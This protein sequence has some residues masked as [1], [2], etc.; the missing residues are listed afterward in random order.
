MRNLKLL[1]PDNLQR[2]LN[3]NTQ[4]ALRNKNVEIVGV[5]DNGEQ[6]YEMIFELKPDIVI[7]DNQIHKL[8]GIEL[9]K[10]IENSDLAYI[11]KFI[12]ITDDTDKISDNKSSNFAVIRKIGKPVKEEILLN[13]IEDM[14]NI[15]K[16]ETPEM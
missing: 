2:N 10:R 15:V 14:I 1:I 6:E 7:T 13:A 3:R 16:L 4:I 11:P 5:T 9:I 12:L 8:S